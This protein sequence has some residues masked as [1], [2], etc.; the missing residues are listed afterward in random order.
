M[1]LFL[2]LSI[3]HNRLN[4]P[5]GDQQPL[6]PA[7]G[8]DPVG[9][10]PPPEPEAAGDRVSPRPGESNQRP[11]LARW[12]APPKRQEPA[13]ASAK[14]PQTPSPPGPLATSLAGWPTGGGRTLASP[15]ASA[16]AAWRSRAS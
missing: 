15:L 10:R 4:Q 2:F 12:L 5:A 9:R 11:G 8:P 1:R 16:S 6:V 13:H 7:G 14:W 3:G